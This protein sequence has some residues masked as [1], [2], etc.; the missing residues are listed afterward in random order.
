MIKIGIVGTGFIGRVHA[1]AYKRIKN[2]RLVAVVDEEVEKGKEF[3]EKF[4]VS[5]YTNI[6]DL[7]NAEDIN[8]VDICTPTYSHLKV[9]EKVANA[10]KNIL[11]EK[12]IAL[13]LEDADKMIDV[14]KKN[15]VNAMVGHVLRFWPEYVKVKEMIDNKELGEP[16]HAYCE[17]LA[18]SPDWRSF[19]DWG[20]KE[21]LSGGVSMD[22]QIHDL[23]YL[24]WLFGMPKLVKS[25]GYYNKA[26]GGL[27][28]VGTG[29]EFENNVSGLSEAGW[30]FQGA[31]P[32][33]MVLRIVCENGTIDWTFRAGKNIEERGKEF[34]LTVYKSDGTVYLPE[35]NKEDPYYLE[36]KYFVD[37]LEEGRKIENATLVDGRNAL[38]VTLLTM[39][40]AKEGG[41]EKI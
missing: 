25:Q 40:S 31:F 10:G 3:A 6:E 38:L 29:L 37:C 21:E 5:S 39:K 33:T 22:L 16:W 1:E 7:F 24:I 2:A 13:T 34:S 18:V 23:D 17:R 28:H 8:A 4:G 12:P 32:F 41:I 30:A 35:V 14:V 36:L 15:N 26:I 27:A 11:C 20:L 19:D 9:V